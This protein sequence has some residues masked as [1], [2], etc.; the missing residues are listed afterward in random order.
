MAFFLREIILV[1]IYCENGVFR[2]GFFLVCFHVVC[3]CMCICI[4]IYYRLVCSD[5][6]V[7]GKTNYLCF[8]GVFAKLNK[9]VIK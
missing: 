1:G 5:R 8:P 6:R 7:V 4:N 9:H 3:M 2:P